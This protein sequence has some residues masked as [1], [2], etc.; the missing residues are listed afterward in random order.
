MKKSTALEKRP[1][2]QLTNYQR[3]WVE[4]DYPFKIG[5]WARQ[6]GKSFGS[7]LEGVLDTM[8]TSVP[9]IL[10]SRGERQ[11]KE[12][13][14]KVQM[15]AKAI[16]VAAKILES[17][18]VGEATYKMLEVRFPNRGKIIGLPANP[19]TAR[20]FSGNVLLDE[21]AFHQ[22]SRKIWTALFPTI[23]RGHKIRVISTANGKQNMF[24]DL[25][26]QNNKF[27]DHKYKTTIYDAK[28]Q[29]LDVDI[30][31]L[32][33]GINDPDAW[34]QEYE[35]QF[36]DEAT[37]YLT[38]EIIAS[39]E[40][41]GAFIN[42]N[43]E[44]LTPNSELYL[45]VDIGRKRDLTIIWL[46]E[47]LGDVLWTRMVKRLEKTPFRI[48]RDELFKFLPMARRCCIDATGL[49]MQLAEEAVEK[50]GSKSEA[51]TF[52]NA[53][54]E[55]LAVTLRR[56]FEDHQVRIPP[57][58]WVRDD[59]HSVKKYVTAAGNVRFD[60][61]RTELGHA[62]HFW[63]AALGAHAASGPPAII[64]YKSTG[65]RVGHEMSDY[66][67]SGSEATNYF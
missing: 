4:D 46:W 47:K 35:C 1:A 25:W 17:N 66:M 34:A 49:G 32:K 6:T 24:Y 11:S 42:F 48:Q 56:R 20:G 8:K 40:D 36:I 54:K 5:L 45:G 27:D 44:L 43:S 51:V 7:S 30:E 64:E 21:F 67:P 38:Y 53:V 28:E 31:S 3:A 12:L 50:F 15:H 59:F 52:T 26:T 37:A 18:W 16:G 10:L 13:I 29:G 2:I 60:A 41:E 14:E 9:W 55:D 65:K 62:D 57:D 22:D 39:C 58:R 23:T 63:A 61:E 19:D 33:E